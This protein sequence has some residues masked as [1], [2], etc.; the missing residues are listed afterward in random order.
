[1]DRAAVL[2]ADYGLAIKSIALDCGYD[3]ISNFYRDFRK[4]HGTTPRQLR[5][6]QLLTDVIE[7]LV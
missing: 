6:D 5:N 2:L 4:V 1:M 7:S 3:D